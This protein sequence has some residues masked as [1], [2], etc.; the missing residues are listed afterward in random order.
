MQARA[1]LLLLG[2]LFAVA[3]PASAQWRRDVRRPSGFYAG[4]SLVYA[5]PE[6]EFRDFVSDG[7]GLQGHLIYAPRGSALGLRVDGGF[8]NYGHERI[9]TPI[10]STIGGRILV[11]LNTDNNIAYL[12]VGPQ[13]GIPRGALQPYLNGF[14]GLAYLFTES[15]LEGAN[16][17]QRFANTTNFDDVAFAYG[18]GGGV[19]IPVRR[20]AS[21]ISIDLGATYH[22]SGEAD[23]LREGGIRDNPDGSVT[24]FPDRS[25]TSLVSF[26]AGVSVGIPRG[27]R[28]DRECRRCRCR[29]RRCR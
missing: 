1:P 7:F 12:G 21:P 26:H 5:R 22:H 14:V 3:S 15:S 9:R 29:G 28:R 25:E 10:S 17:N 13:L 18:G 27:G 2:I 19:Y 11:D 8:L 16:D 6:G 24:L 20:G 23:Y 4:G